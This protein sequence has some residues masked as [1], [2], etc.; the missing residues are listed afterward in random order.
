MADDPQHEMIRYPT[1]FKVERLENGDYVFEF[2]DLTA[3]TV[4]RFLVSKIWAVKLGDALISQTRTT[5]LH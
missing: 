2:S 5:L 4:L 3:P 1:R